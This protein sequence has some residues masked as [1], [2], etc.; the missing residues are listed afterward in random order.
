MGTDNVESARILKKAEGRR[1]S[2]R[3]APN[4]NLSQ[5]QKC[6]LIILA[7]IL[8]VVAIVVLHFRGD[9]LQNVA[10]VERLTLRNALLS[11]ANLASQLFNFTGKKSYEGKNPKAPRL[12]KRKEREPMLTK[13]TSWSK[14]FKTS[15]DVSS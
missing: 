11:T 13:L 15:E 7:R 4:A 6:A 12:S 9:G 1:C 10:Q 14:K 3:P 2:K 8:K 5:L